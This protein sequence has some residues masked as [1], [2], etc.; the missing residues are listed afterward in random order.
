MLLGLRSKAVVHVVDDDAAVDGHVGEEQAIHVCRAADH[1]SAV[2]VHDGRPLALTS[3]ELGSRVMVTGPSLTLG[4][5]T[6][7]LTLYW[8]SWLVATSSSVLSHAAYAWKIIVIPA[9]I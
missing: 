7:T 6:S 8:P 1:P 2:G 9:S 3:Q 5:C 4:V